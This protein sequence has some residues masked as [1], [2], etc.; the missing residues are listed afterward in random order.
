MNR[1]D[2][3]MFSKLIIMESEIH[4]KKLSTPMIKLYFNKLSEFSLEQVEAALKHRYK[5]M[6]KPYELAEKIEG[7]AHDMRLTRAHDQADLVQHVL[8]T[9]GS[10]SPV[11]FDDPITRKLMKTRWPLH[12]WGKQVT[13]AELKWWRKDFVEA[14]ISQKNVNEHRQLTQGEAVKMLEGLKP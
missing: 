13:T 12:I 4:G 9:H 7:P 10:D 14:Y 3:K 11:V 1:Q 8:E 2:F 6:P 5:F